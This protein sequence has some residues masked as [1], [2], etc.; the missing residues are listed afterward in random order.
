MNSLRDS[1]ASIPGA[2][3]NFISDTA[4][5]ASSYI[6]IS[7]GFHGQNDSMSTGST[8]ESLNSFNEMDS[9]S[10]GAVLISEKSLPIPASLVK[11]Q[12][13]LI[14]TSDASEQDRS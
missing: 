3:T 1:L 9:S 13:R 7:V 6:P 5:V 12:W 2:V 11:E 14:F 10:T 8:T 4:S